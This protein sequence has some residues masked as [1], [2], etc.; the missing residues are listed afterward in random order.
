MKRPRPAAAAGFTLVELLVVIGIIAVL[1]SLLLPAIQRA[2][3]HAVSVQCL[4]NLKQIGQA[5]L[6]YAAE[7]KGYYPTAQVNS[8]ENI[9][10][11][12]AIDNPGGGAW[13][14]YVP[15][16]APAPLANQSSSHFN[17]QAFYKFLNK[18]T[19]V[20]YCPANILWEA[21]SPPGSKDA[22]DPKWFTEPLMSTPPN[23]YAHVRI[24]YWYMANPWRPSG[25]Q[26]TGVDAIAGPA[27]RGYSQWQDIDGDGDRRDE[28]L[29]KVG[30]KNA[31]NIAI[32]TDQSRQVSPGVPGP[33]GWFFLHG[34]AGFS[35]R[36][37]LNS[38]YV[39]GS[40]KNNL[41]G[42]GHATSVRPDEVKWRWGRI[43]SVAAAW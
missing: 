3:T 31:A 35:N 2:R 14:G 21:D 22:H 1:I 30:E 32:A 28:Y 10:G 37:D 39:K 9:T 27:N 36:S 25:P 12:G 23:E 18:Q 24:Q 26:L 43:A 16:G 42:D 13:T 15:P 8:I 40:W 7:N 11:G 4:S 38:S 5:A 33:G 20:F 17:K 41:Y 6:M 29:C 34:K 19:Q